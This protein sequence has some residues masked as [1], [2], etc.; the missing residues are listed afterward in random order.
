MLGGRALPVGNK[1]NFFLLLKT[2]TIWIIFFPA[3]ITWVGA[4]SRS[5]RTLALVFILVDVVVIFVFVIDR[6]S[7]GCIVWQRCWAR[8]SCVFC[9]YF[10]YYYFQTHVLIVLYL[11]IS[12]YLVCW[13]VFRP[14]GTREKHFSKNS[15]FI[16]SFVYAFFLSS[17]QSGRRF[18]VHK[19]LLCASSKV[20]NYWHKTN[21]NALLFSTI[22]S[23]KIVFLGDAWTSEHARSSSN[24]VQRMRCK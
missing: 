24:F 10:C 8:T 18:G 11:N 15:F 23:Y 3:Q 7:V 5:Q 16:I 21:K 22:Y 1:I 2:C 4:S 19:A 12:Q 14:E 9:L 6:V 17:T 13:C 20:E